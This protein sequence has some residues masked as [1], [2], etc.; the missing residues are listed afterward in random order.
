MNSHSEIWHVENF[1]M[2]GVLKKEELKKIDEMAK[3]EESPS[4]HALYYLDNQSTT[5][6]LLK[7]EK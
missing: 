1:S 5:I 3:I 6:F 2:L 4:N 7:R